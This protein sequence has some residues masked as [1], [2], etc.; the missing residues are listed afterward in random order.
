[1]TDDKSL[2]P[3]T[4]R[5]CV[6]LHTLVQ[7]YI[8]EGVPVGSRALSGELTEK[9]SPAT[10]R[11]VMAELERQ[12]YVS[13]PHTS[14]G[15]IP[16]VLGYRFFVN[17]LVGVQPVQKTFVDALAREFG[18]AADRSELVR[19]A[20]SLLSGFT[21]LAGVVT[22]PRVETQIFEQIEFLPLSDQR[23]LAV[24]VVNG[25]EVQNKIINVDPVPGRTELTRISNYI[26]RHFGGQPLEEVRR[27]LF[28]ELNTARAEVDQLMQQA[29][30]V[31]GRVLQ[32]E[33]APQQ[34]DFILDGETNLMEYDELANV[35]ELRRLFDVFH[36]KRE[37]LYLLDQCIRADRVQIFIGEEAGYEEFNQVSLVTAPYKFD[38]KT[39]GVLGV[40]GPTR[41]PYQSVV[42]IVDVTA[43]LLSAALNSKG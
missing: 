18:R 17:A 16:T 31:A 40:I 3:L 33:P 23:L 29:M 36:E 7:K 12:G 14:A 13:S 1:M 19:Q 11:N 41:I 8:K 15:R 42:A 2:P 6:L 20:S 39:A 9:L 4:D 25:A 28:E 38:G 26:N 34:G 24:I 30:D 35:A 32:P 43:K 5:A 10:I 21:R 37:M 22:L 27:Q